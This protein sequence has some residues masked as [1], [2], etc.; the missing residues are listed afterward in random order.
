LVQIVQDKALELDDP[1]LDSHL[2]FLGDQ[3][4][5]HLPSLGLKYRFYLSNLPIANAFSIAGGRIYVTRKLIGF[6][7]S[8]DELVGVMAHEIGHIVTHQ[9]A[10]DYTKFFNSIGINE[11]GDQA[12]IE[13]KFHRLLESGKI[14]RV[15]GEERQLEADRVGLELTALSGYQ[16]DGLANFF[17]RATNNRGKTGNWFTEL[18]GTTPENSKRLREMQKTVR[19]FPS[20]CISHSP[21][22]SSSFREWQTKV[23]SYPGTGR[24]EHIP[25]LESKKPLEPP[26]QDEVHTLRFSYDGKYLLAQDDGSIYVLTREPLAFKFRIEAADAYPARFAPDSKQ[27][28]FYDPELRV[29]TW[30]VEEGNRVDVREVVSSF[31][32][33]QTALS[34][35]SNT[36]ACVDNKETLVLFDTTTSDRIYEKQR[37][38]SGEFARGAN[39][40]SYSYKIRFLNMGFSLDSRYLLVAGGDFVFA[41]D[42]PARHEVPVKSALKPFLHGAFSFTGDRT[43]VGNEKNGSQG[44]VLD[45]PEGTILHSI[46]LGAS[47]PFPVAKGDFVLMRP[48][49]DYPVGVL[50]IRSNSI[51]RA[52]K[53]P[54]M[55]VY[56]DIAVSMLPSG[57]VGLFGTSPT[58]I[59]KLALPRGHFGSVRAV[60]FSDDLNWLA[61]STRSRGSVWNLATGGRPYNLKG[62]RGACF[63][64]DG[65]LYM[66]FPKQEKVDRSIV[67]ADLHQVQM[68]IVEKVETGRAWQECEYLVRL[69]G[70]DE[71]D[72]AKNKEKEAKDPDEEDQRDYRYEGTRMS[73]RDVYEPA[74]TN[75]ILEVH[76]ALTGALLWSK[77]FNKV[78][79]AIYTDASA[80]VAAFRWRLY[81]DGA[82]AEMKTMPTVLRPERG[83]RDDDYL[84]EVV[85]LHNGKFLNAI[86][87]DTANGAINL[88]R[89]MATMDWVV[90]YDSI[91]RTLVYSLK[92]GK[93]VDKLF[94]TPR[95]LSLSGTL[96]VQHDPGHL[97]LHDLNTSEKVD[98]T[99]PFPVSSTFFTRNGKKLLLLTNDQVVYTINTMRPESALR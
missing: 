79:P 46:E 84:I 3:L 73:W 2:Q 1:E 87:I 81:S 52:S 60:N 89:Y 26:L 76:D 58:P 96:V 98:V 50:D 15:N 27:I 42:V 40:L 95:N 25:G 64:K 77:A 72:A 17:D 20:E 16:T 14:F 99:L 24:R 51:I 31:G 66:D 69:A 90:V 62:F 91:G 49:H 92:T 33:L 78:I 80:N 5:V 70:K 28:T 59:A 44:A 35:D 94:G 39:W 65:N 68:S 22:S 30:D 19:H 12:D 45:F 13:A 43:L 67:R 21:H 71:D 86:I 85:D 82:K 63:A 48:I 97:T 8:E 41:L 7:H 38:R 55:D 74:D 57:E 29:E 88:R 83:D 54:A 61:V 93:C 47:A 6:V 53:T 75:K 37:I 18:F 36:L 56:G 32:C 23:V 9:T 4:A 11:V 10:I 34:P